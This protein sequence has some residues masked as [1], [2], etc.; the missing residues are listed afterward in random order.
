MLKSVLKMKYKFQL[1]MVDSDKVSHIF[2]E[3]ERKLVIDIWHAYIFIQSLCHKQDSAQD[4]F[5]SRV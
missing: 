5:L 3:E 1:N 4:K 2:K